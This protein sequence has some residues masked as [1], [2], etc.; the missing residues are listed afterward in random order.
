M[1]YLLSF[2][3]PV[4]Y[5]FHLRCLCLED[6]LLSSFHPTTKPPF[7]SSVVCL[8]SSP[9]PVNQPL[10]FF[11]YVSF[12]CWVN[13]YHPYPQ[14]KPLSSSY[15]TSSWPGGSRPFS[16]TDFLSLLPSS[17][18]PSALNQ[19]CLFQTIAIFLG[20]LLFPAHSGPNHR[21]VLRDLTVPRAQ[22]S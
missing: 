4:N 19:S 3:H 22:W 10:F 12:A 18:L 9:H 15:F 5:P 16:V 21:N 13:L 20:S 6:H 7:L 8:P 14:R 1:G 17:S 11:F 2:P